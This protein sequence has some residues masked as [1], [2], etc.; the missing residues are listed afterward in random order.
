MVHGIRCH[1]IWLGLS[2]KKSWG[3][4]SSH[5]EGSQ[6]RLE[7]G[8][9]PKPA[10]N[11][12]S[13]A[14]GDLAIYWKS[15]NLSSKKRERAGE[16]CHPRPP[17]SYKKRERRFW[18]GPQREWRTWRL[19]AERG[20]QATQSKSGHYQPRSHGPR[21]PKWEKGGC[22]EMEEYETTAREGGI[23]GAGG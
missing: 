7:T 10:A 3:L 15:P 13:T 4:P 8:V 1:A 22:T 19:G 6:E 2:I 23:K 5:L 11:W 14:N 16:E 20:G 12:T 18:R 9:G 21:D 17:A